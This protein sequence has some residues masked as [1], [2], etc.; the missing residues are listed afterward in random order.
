MSEFR[1]RLMMTKS[2]GGSIPNYLCFTALGSGTV[3][4][5]IGA[6][7]TT[8]YVTDVSYSVDDGRTWVKTNNSN[9]SVVITT[10]SLTAGEKV[11]WKG[12]AI[13]MAIPT[14]TTAASRN[15]NSSIFS[16]TCQYDVSG[17]LLS[18]LFEDNFDDDSTHSL[19]GK[20][21]CFA[22]MFFNGLCK[23]CSSL[24][25]SENDVSS[26]CFYQTFYGSGITKTPQLPATTLADFCYNNTFNGCRSLTGSCVLPAKI[27]TNSCYFSAFR[28]SGIQSI[29]I[30]GENS[31]VTNC[32]RQV[33][34][35]ASSCNYIKLMA[36]PTLSN[37]TEFSRNVAASG[38]FVKHIDA[39]W[40]TTGYDG[41]PTGWTVIYYDPAVDKYYTDQTRATECD[42]HG[43]PL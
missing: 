28:S 24:I 32:L 39:T 1:R 15:N 19:S 11:Y 7:V 2:G 16:S 34:R 20:D 23:D 27:L 14:G 13:K 29:E 42:D 30:I 22:N 40:T 25:I 4:L 43:N 17:N 12:N 31:N 26:Y 18:L 35:D 3:T 6:N 33:L 5:T 8:D 10:P 9:S 21:Y 41:V 36:N 37:S 38:I